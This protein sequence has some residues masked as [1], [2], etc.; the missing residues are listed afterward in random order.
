VINDKETKNGRRLNNLGDRGRAWGLQM[1]E[2]FA[3]IAKP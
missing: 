1:E 2:T 3:P